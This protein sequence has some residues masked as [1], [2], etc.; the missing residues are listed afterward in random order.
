MKNFSFYLKKK[1]KPL[2]FSCCNS[3]LQKQNF[4]FFAS[5]FTMSSFLEK[6]SVMNRAIAS[7]TSSLF[8]MTSYKKAFHSFCFLQSHI[9]K[10]MQNNFFILVDL[11]KAKQKKRRNQQQKSSSFGRSNSSKQKGEQKKGI[12]KSNRNSKQ[13]I[14]KSGLWNIEQVQHTFHKQCI[15]WQWQ[16]NKNNK[17]KI[18]FYFNFFLFFKKNIIVQHCW[19]EKNKFWKICSLFNIFLAPLFSRKMKNRK[20]QFLFFKKQNTL[21]LFEKK[22]FFMNFFSKNEEFQKFEIKIVQWFFFPFFKEEHKVSG[23]LDLSPCLL[24]D[25]LKQFASYGV[26]APNKIMGLFALNKSW[27]AQ[28]LCSLEYR[29][30]QFCS[31]PFP[32]FFL[33]KK[34]EMKNVFKMIHIFFLQN[35]QK[36]KTIKKKED[37]SFFKSKSIFSF[38]TKNFQSIC[39]KIKNLKRKDLYNSVFFEFQWWVFS[40]SQILS[41]FFESLFWKFFEFNFTKIQNFLPNLSSFFLQSISICPFFFLQENKQTNKNFLFSFFC[42]A[43]FF[44]FSKTQK[45]LDFLSSQN[46][47]QRH[48]LFIMKQVVDFLNFHFEFFLPSF[49]SFATMQ[50]KNFEKNFFYIFKRFPTSIFQKNCSASFLLNKD[51]EESTKNIFSFFFPSFFGRPLFYNFKRIEKRNIFMLLKNELFFSKV[52]FYSNSFHSSASIALFSLSFFTQGFFFRKIKKMQ[53]DDFFKNQLSKKQHE[54]QSLSFLQNKQQEKNKFLERFCFWFSKQIQQQSQSSM[55]QNFDKFC[56][57]FSFQQ[58]EKCFFHVFENLKHFISLKQQIFQFWMS[59]KK[60]FFDFEFLF[61][62]KKKSLFQRYSFFLLFLK[63]SFLLK[64]KLF[65]KKKKK[66]SLLKFFFLKNS[67][68]FQTGK[69]ILFSFCFSNSLLLEKAEIPLF[70]FQKKENRKR[71]QSVNKEKNILKKKP[72]NVRFLSFSNIQDFVENF[73]NFFYSFSKIQRFVPQNFIFKTFQEKKQK[74]L[75]LNI[76]FLKN[77]FFFE[78]IFFQNN[79]FQ[80]KLGKTFFL[81]SKKIFFQNLKTNSEKFSQFSFF[82]YFLFFFNQII[83]PSFFSVVKSKIQSK[84]VKKWSRQFSQ[85]KKM[86][87]L[88]FK[89]SLFCLNFKNFFVFLFFEFQKMFGVSKNSLKKQKAS[90]I[91][92]FGTMPSQ[93]A[94][95]KHL[96]ECKDVVQKQKGKTLNFFS[97]LFLKKFQNKK[98]SVFYGRGI[99]KLQK[100]IQI[101]CKKYKSPFTKEIFEYC[102]FILLK[103][104]WNWAQK[105]HPNKSKNWIRKK[106]FHLVSKKKWF[107]GK[108]WKKFV[109]CVPLHSEIEK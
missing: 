81:F 38:P 103:F 18:F 98:F 35:E 84:N 43:F 36:K 68:F 47:V 4:F 86:S 74:N 87:F 54:L 11:Q 73:E 10:F 16:F 39:G 102:D 72:H 22:F 17:K 23:K 79:F 99:Q 96:Q 88:K 6:K 65:S 33:K 94:V 55:F 1:K 61:H 28:Q 53:S 2:F 67:F 8:L 95:K 14:Q 46:K 69:N 21:N 3:F 105:T 76:F 107:F 106:Y 56:F 100:K 58:L 51:K 31:N 75:F 104:L 27:Q 57:T 85:R 97:V 20:K 48:F 108:K 44:C 41:I 49:D 50:K 71:N 59:L 26:I 52:H 62:F 7:C 91:F 60:L 32:F 29:N 5:F 92:L 24:Y 13:T 77:S 64:P 66:I 80:K 109:I 63:N 25:K 9:H 78:N 19:S 30:F 93:Q 70:S 15:L 42:F 12:S 37:K 34:I 89:K 90:T 45:L 40:F 82:F 83:L 101:W